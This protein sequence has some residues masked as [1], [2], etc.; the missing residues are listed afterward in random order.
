MIT[1]SLHGRPVAA[2]LPY[3]ATGFFDDRYFET[4]PNSAELRFAPQGDAG[5]VRICTK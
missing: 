5:T 4:V 1:A 2:G 3:R